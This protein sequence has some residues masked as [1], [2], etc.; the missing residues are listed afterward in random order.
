MVQITVIFQGNIFEKVLTMVQ[1]I[2]IFEKV[3]FL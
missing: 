3:E 2:V 1:I